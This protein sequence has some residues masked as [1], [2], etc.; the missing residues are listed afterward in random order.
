M[1]QGKA[2][3]AARYLAQD[4][5]LGTALGGPGAGGQPAGGSLGDRGEE[6][7]AAQPQRPGPPLRLDPRPAL[8][9]RQEGPAPALD[10]LHQLHL[11]P[12]RGL[13]AGVEREQ[14]EKGR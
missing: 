5:E 7:A 8:G 2:R 12:R 13:E 4:D 1:G 3:D 14:N 10:R 9:A 6:L 11:P